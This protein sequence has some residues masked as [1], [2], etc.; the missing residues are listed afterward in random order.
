MGA[1][2]T[3]RVRNISGACPTMHVGHMT[4]HTLPQLRAVH[5]MFFANA[6]MPLGIIISVGSRKNI[7][8]S[9]EKFSSS[10]LMLQCFPLMLYLKTNRNDISPKCFK[11]LNL[12]TEILIT[13][14]STLWD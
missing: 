7:I 5:V 9:V 6:S 13:P 10:L 11:N 14:T 4:S 2:P 3:N 1:C 8:C 12:C